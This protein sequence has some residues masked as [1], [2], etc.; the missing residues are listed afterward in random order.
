ML[1]K[2]RL[3]R[4][5]SSQSANDLMIAVTAPVVALSTIAMG[6]PSEVAPAASY[7][8]RPVNV[9]KNDRRTSSFHYNSMP[10]SVARMP[11]RREAALR[12]RRAAR[13]VQRAH[14]LSRQEAFDRLQAIAIHAAIVF[15]CN[16]TEVRQQ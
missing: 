5:S 16:I 8:S 7:L 14:R 1:R 2:R 6:P 3:Q 12:P 10:R 13:C 15:L 11:R 4:A 9:T